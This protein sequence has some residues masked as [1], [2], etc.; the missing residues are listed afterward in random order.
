MLNCEISEAGRELAG[1]TLKIREI[2]GDEILVVEAVACL[3]VLRVGELD[4]ASPEISLLVV[5][6]RSIA[7]VKADSGIASG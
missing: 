6:G 5:V 7:R 1:M 2:R 4:I 3:Q